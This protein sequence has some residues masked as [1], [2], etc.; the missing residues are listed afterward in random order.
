MWRKCDRCEK[1]VESYWMIGFFKYNKK[2]ERYV[3]DT[4]KM[5]RLCEG[6]MN[7]INKGSK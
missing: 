5:E 7:G 3:P 1:Q 4:N 6:C 2:L